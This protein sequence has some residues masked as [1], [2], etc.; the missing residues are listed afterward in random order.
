MK[1][2]VA[3]KIRTTFE[4]HG[5]IRHDD[6]YWMN[7][8]TNPEVI[9]HLEAENAYFKHVMAPLEEKQNAS[10]HLI[11]RCIFYSLFIRNISICGILSSKYSS[12][13]A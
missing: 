13:I 8:K 6:Y 10:L 3:R 9:A 5:D 11:G 12:E 2:P 1:Q 4:N 7:Q